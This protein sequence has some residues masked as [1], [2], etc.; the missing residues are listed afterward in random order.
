M[1][2]AIGVWR[3]RIQN[4]N[5]QIPRQ[6]TFG[7]RATKRLRV[8]EAL[9]PNLTWPPYAPMPKSTRNTRNG[10]SGAAGAC[11]KAAC[12]LDFWSLLQFCSVPGG[13]GAD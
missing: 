4:E 11:A 10:F 3:G 13:A 6:R 5:R 12:L 8:R 1:A 2:R 7:L 9:K